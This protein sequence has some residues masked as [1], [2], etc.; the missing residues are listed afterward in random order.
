MKFKLL[1]FVAIVSIIAIYLWQKPTPQPIVR[2]ALPEA[3]RDTVAGPVIGFVDEDDTLG[4]LGIPFAA[5]PL[6]ELRWAA[7][8]LPQPWQKNRDAIAFENTCVQLWGPL[9]G[10]TGEEGQVVG[11]EDC[12]YL[13]VW[14]PRNN[15]DIDS[16]G[17]PVMFWIHGGGNSIGTA[18]TYPGHRLAGGENVVLVTINYRLGLLGWMSHP[19][20]RGEG[21]SASD[22]SGNYGNLDMIA[23]LEWVQKNI[24]SFGG[25]PDNVTIFGESAG[26]L[27]V[28]SLMASPPAKGLF[29][30]AIA[31]SGSTSTT[32]L[33]RAE[34]FTDGEQPGEALSSREWLSM[35]LQHAGKAQD[36]KTAKVAQLALS[37]EE[38]LAFMHSRS[39]EQILK[40]IS[41]G[42]G[43]YRAPQNLR[44]GTILPKGSLLTLFQS[45][46]RYNDVPL[47]TGTNRD[48]A[49]LFM[50]QDPN[51]VERRFGFLPHIKDIDAYNRTS[52][53]ISD[54]WKARAVDEVAAVI[55][56]NSKQAVYAYRW[57]WDEGAKSWLVDYST[58][59]GAGHGMEVA[60]V[61][62]DFD[63][64]ILVP[65]FYNEENS[66]GRDELARE[67]RS[68]W[69]QFATTGDPASGRNGDL[70]KWDAWNDSG[71]NL[72]ILDSTS[73][74]GSKMSR[75]PMTIAML[76]QRLAE[77][78]DIVD[79]KV[80]CRTH[81]ELFLKVNSGDD[82]WNEQEYLDLGCAKYNPWTIMQP[83]GGSIN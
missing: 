5:P 20:L 46:E 44:D 43:M 30:R 8:R 39:P 45:P 29:H 26:G 82:Y 9:V 67:M 4:W 23:A 13:N 55:S 40:G 62:D 81:A 65:G 35:Q 48:E 60:F 78:T 28:Y 66:P 38:I 2:I 52:A 33:W 76:K 17:L 32:P 19:A 31:Q 75:E 80:R 77:D 11:N 1:A 6:G 74:G 72:M 24:T 16:V 59:I 64:G 49:K 15:S 68:Y 21:R 25:D 73:S 36:R 83:A 54:T 50:A 58:L 79:T 56:A 7:P 34:N 27:N 61:F 57:D 41:G 53:Y 42:A 14:A 63:G 70:S 71:P 12:L 37:D 3:I 47:M 10:I 69:S 22:A 51:F 18:N